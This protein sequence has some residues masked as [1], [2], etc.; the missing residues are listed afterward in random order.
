MTRVTVVAC[1]SLLLA[2]CATQPIYVPLSPCH[3][4]S[5]CAPESAVLPPSGTLAVHA[6]EMMPPY[7]DWQIPGIRDSERHEHAAGPFPMHGVPMMDH[8]EP[9]GPPGMVKM[10]A[11]E[12]VVDYAPADGA[13]PRA[14]AAAG[15]DEHEP[16][17]HLEHTS[18]ERREAPTSQ[19]PI[20][21][22]KQKR[23]SPM[24][25]MEGHEGHGVPATPSGHEG[26][27]AAATPSQAPAPEPS[28]APA[29]PSPAAAP[30]GHE[31]HH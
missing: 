17:R 21:P 7:P 10:E 16:E 23:M 2:A 24:P 13:P 20:A 29:A 15:L 14:P 26:H 25:A 5:P 22:P 12:Q 27:G 4:A 6:R 30:A 11:P 19:A 9:G 3:P 18:R 8:P 28:S 31:G 1:C